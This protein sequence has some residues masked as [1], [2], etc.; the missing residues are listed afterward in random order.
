MPVN[1]RNSPDP[2]VITTLRAEFGRMR[3]EL[4]SKIDSLKAHFDAVIA[5]KDEEIYRIG[6]ENK[7]LKD[8]ITRLEEKL[9]DSDAYE[10]RDCVVLSGDSIPAANI[11]E[12]CK[13][14]AV[15]LIKEKLRINL[16]S[17]DISTAHRLGRKSITQGPDRR[18]VILKL[19]RRDLKRDI[20]AACKE[21]KPGFFVNESLTP[22]RN[23]ILFAL[24][25][26]RRIG[27]DSPVKGTATIDG[28]VFVWIRPEGSTRDQR[29][30]INT[31]SKLREFSVDVMKKPLSDCV[32][33]LNFQ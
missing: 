11:G 33:E 32:P 31:V 4:S 7:E 10:R 6:K 1:T 18:K 5:Q 8:C 20:I 30:Q 27:P 25:R 16:Q 28:K 23:S 17:S 14:V 15:Q 12:N 19:C 9:D 29:L 22:T 2:E 21:L 13:E 26:M 24:R 3:D